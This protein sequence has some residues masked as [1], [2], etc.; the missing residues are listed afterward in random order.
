MSPPSFGALIHS[1]S[2]SDSGGCSLYLLIKCRT[3][4]WT[5]SPARRV[6]GYFESSMWP[7]IRSLGTFDRVVLAKPP[8]PSLDCSDA[9]SQFFDELGFRVF[10]A[11]QYVVIYWSPRLPRHRRLG[12][13]LSA[14]ICAST[15]SGFCNKFLMMPLPS[16]LNLIQIALAIRFLSRSTLF[17]EQLIPRLSVFD[18]FEPLQR[19]QRRRTRFSMQG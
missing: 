2:Y 5:E 8:L 16:S 3:L 10:S 12:F 14:T 7:G 9:T 19:F 13:G 6:F 1:W 4:Q 17:P 15:D 11:S 18:T